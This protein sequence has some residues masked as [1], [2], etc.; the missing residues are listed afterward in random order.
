MTRAPDVDPA[1][2]A[3]LKN[4]GSAIADDDADEL[5]VFVVV[6]KLYSSARRPVSYGVLVRLNASNCR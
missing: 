1:L 2:G 5:S 6:F 4:L 3:A